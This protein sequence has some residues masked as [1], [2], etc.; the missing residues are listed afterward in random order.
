MSTEKEI[1]RLQAEV[2]VLKNND[3]VMD[4]KLDLLIK[5]ADEGKGARKVLHVIY[6]CAIALATLR[7]GDIKELF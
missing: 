5:A 2:D 1:G 3:K 4:L 7:L 6:I